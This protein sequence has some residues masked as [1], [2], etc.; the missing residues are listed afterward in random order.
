[1]LCARTFDE[2]GVGEGINLG[3]Y[4]FKD[5]HSINFWDNWTRV[6]VYCLGIR[7]IK[8]INL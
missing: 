2:M 3:V 8:S 4:I 6:N 7:G 5:M 1:M